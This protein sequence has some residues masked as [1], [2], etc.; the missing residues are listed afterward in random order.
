MFLR[1]FHVPVSGVSFVTAVRLSAKENFRIAAVLFLI[2]QKMGMD[3]SACRNISM[4]NC[5]VPY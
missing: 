5:R 2:P 1:V 4:R 3:F